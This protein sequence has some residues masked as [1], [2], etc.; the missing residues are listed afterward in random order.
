MNAVIKKISTI[1]SM[2]SF[3]T[4]AAILLGT[5]IFASSGVRVID[6]EA[7]LKEREGLNLSRYATSIKYIP[8]E[9][10]EES[11]LGEVSSFS[12]DGKNFYLASLNGNSALEFSSDGK[13]VKAIGTKGRGPGEHMGINK[14][15][16]THPSLQNV[17][18]YRKM[19]NV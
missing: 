13:F 17:S 11:L 15:F 2:R 19:E 14:I 18:S 5:Q 7:A 4:I 16:P 3:L 1:K 9:T 6:A 12:T 8:L 10:T